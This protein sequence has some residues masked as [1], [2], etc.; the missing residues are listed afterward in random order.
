MIHSGFFLSGP[1]FNS[2][3]TTS[4]ISISVS[5]EDGAMADDI[6]NEA[7][8]SVPPSFWVKMAMKI[9]RARWFIFLRRVFHYQNGSR[10]DLGPNP[11]NSGLWMAMELVAL[12]FQLI[13]S[14]F[15]LAISQA[16]KPVWPMRLWI[17]GYDLGCV[18]SL[19][20]LYGRHRY[21][22]LMQGN[23]NRLSDIE[24]EQQRSNESS[25]Y[26]HLMNRCRTSLDLFFAIWFVMGNLWVF[27]SRLA[28]FQRAPKL[29]LLCSFLLV[30]NAICYS[31]PFIL[32]LLLC[33]CVPLI[34]SLTGYNIN[35]GSSEKGASDD[36]ISQ[37]PCWRYKAVEANI[38]PRS[39][40]DNSN[41]GLLKEDPECCICLAKY[42]DKEE[43]RQLPCSHV[44][45]LKCVDKWLAITSSCPL[46]KQQL[47]R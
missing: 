3:A 19:L 36:Q 10:S 13:I 22:Y 12:L 47:Q 25:R 43:V 5:G 33:C 8:D 2:D 11:F 38:N 35:M 40:P 34:S 30:W 28:S 21:H 45:H 31:F 18:L 29:H 15:T 14:V 20:L 39:Q 32:F 41:T 4:F 37:L 7:S 6:R 24:H 42:I 44:F 9:S 23:D 16:E 17:G 26:S 1:S 27:D 46:C